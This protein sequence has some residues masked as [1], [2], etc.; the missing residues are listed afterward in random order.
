MSMVSRLSEYF[1]RLKRCPVSELEQSLVRLFFATLF[2]LYLWSFQ[3]SGNLPSELSKPLFQVAGTYLVLSLV[4]FAAIVTW[5]ER[6]KVRRVVSTALDAGMISLTMWLGGEITSILYIFYLWIS[7]G[8]GLR[9]GRKY[10]LLASGLSFAG[11]SLVIAQSEFWSQHLNLSLGL[12]FGLLIIPLFVAS[13][14]IRLENEKQGAEAANHAKSRFLANMSH[15]IRTPLNGVVGMSDLLVGTPL[16]EEQQD[17]VR[18]IHSSAESLLSLIEDILDIS[19]IEAGKVA[20]SPVDQDLYALTSDIIGMIR[21]QAVSKTISL[22]LWIETEVPP[23]VRLDPLLLRQILVNLLSNAV[24]FTEEGGVILRVSLASYER[25]D[26]PSE[27]LLFEVIDTGIGVS[28]EHLQQIFERFTQLDDSVTRRYTGTGLGTTI[29]KQLVELLGGRIGVESQVGS[30][31]RFWFE[32][33][34]L[35][36]VN[37]LDEGLLQAAQWILFSNAKYGESNILNYMQECNLVTKVSRTSASGFQ[38]LMNAVALNKPYDVAIVDEADVEIP[39]DQLAHTIRGEPHL[40]GLVFILVTEMEID[41]ERRRYLNQAGFSVIISPPFTMQ[42]IRHGLYYALL[43]RSKPAHNGKDTATGI[44]TPL[45]ARAYKVLLAE[46]NYINQKVVQK[47]LQRA[48]HA[49]DVTDTGKDALDALISNQYDLVILDMQMPDMDGLEVIKQYQQ[50]QT[51]PPQVPFMMLTANATIDAQE[52]CRE[53]GVCAFLTK[54]VR[55]GQLVSILDEIL[56]GRSPTDVEKVEPPTHLAS[57]DKEQQEMIIDTGVIDDLARLSKNPLFLDELAEKFYKDSE[58]LLDSMRES[59]TE[60]DVA[61]YRESAHALGG[62]AAGMGAHAL[63]AACDAG[64]GIDQREFNAIGENLFAETLTA[65]SMTCQTLGRILS[66]RK[67][68]GA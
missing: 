63:K 40:R 56:S 5:P 6:Y 10:L 41:A 15:E 25:E 43:Q 21:P 36:V 55:S 44:T 16:N 7:L 29:T 26:I 20:I 37:G 59:V 23:V 11:F 60:K 17:I 58:V 33:P 57:M 12:L 8:N 61:A 27:R 35:E 1:P 46:D 30:G 50:S 45:S 24:K 64:A 14:L 2:I 48:G 31:S 4:V 42:K 52:Q 62:N 66:N 67:S 32:L 68:I 9:Y 54:P 65:Y 18:S 34:L 47:I 13:L 19:K 49:V 39:V 51:E 53:L 28:E 3:L 22:D 38:E